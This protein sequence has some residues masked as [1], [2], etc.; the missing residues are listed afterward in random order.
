M[1]T[2]IHGDHKVEIHMGFWGN[3]RVFYDGCLV[4]D[5]WSVAGTTH[6]F[7]AAEEDQPVQYEVT[8]GPRWYLV[9]AWCEVRRNGIT[10]YTDR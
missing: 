1:R 10:V 2:V 8:I 9:S 4:S 3:E 6:I 7:R 5:K